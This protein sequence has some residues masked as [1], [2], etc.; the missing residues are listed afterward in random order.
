MTGILPTLFG[1]QRSLFPAPLAIRPGFSWRNFSCLCCCL[2]FYH[3]VLWLQPLLEK[4]NGKKQKTKTRKQTTQT[5][6][7]ILPLI[8]TH[9]PGLLA[10]KK[11]VLLEF[12][13]LHPLCSSNLKST[14]KRKEEKAQKC[15]PKW[16]PF[17]SFDCPP[18]SSCCCLF[19]R[20]RS[21]FLHFAHSLEIG[22]SE[23]T[24]SGLSPVA[25]PPSL[26]PFPSVFPTPHR[27]FLSS[28]PFF[29]LSSLLWAPRSKGQKRTSSLLVVHSSSWKLW[30][31]HK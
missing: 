7:H 17:S 16:V 20:A 12:C 28:L 15:T 5:S 21:F 29:S 26:F 3:A 14:L 22:D 19:F 13:C 10:E 2:L 4:K 31:C 1:S 27:S 23:L 11:R 8:G 30:F 24:P 6:L 25:P 18:Q 9:F